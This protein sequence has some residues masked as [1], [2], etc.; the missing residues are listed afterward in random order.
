MPGVAEYGIFVLSSPAISVAMSVYNCE[1]Y[2]VLAIDSILQ[3]S[4]TDFE[5]LIL[6]DGSTD[7]SRAIIDHYAALDSRIRPIHRENKG[8][9]I[10][11][12]QLV[13]EAKAPLIARMDGDDI[14]RPERFA[15]QM[16]FLAANPDYGVLGT[17]TADIDEKGDPFIVSGAD[18]PTTYE[19]FLSAIPVRSALCHPSIIMRRDLVLAAGGYHAAFKHCEDYDLWLRLAHMTKICSLPERLIKYRHSDGQVSNKHIVA[20]QYGT[21]VSRLAYHARAAGRDDPTEHLAELPPLESLDALFN[22]PGAAREARA[23]LVAGLLYSPVAMTSDGFGLLLDHV[24]DGGSKKGLWRTVIR[25]LVR[26]GEPRRAWMLL[27]T[28][29]TN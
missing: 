1:A 20:Q 12:N 16:E 21:V 24:R 5:F 7:G 10:S 17:W 9:I 25:L 6:N 22:M 15:K 14:A 26:M 23:M 3:Q 2:L 4:F 28:L 29:L 13:T 11:L 8:L 27:N 19:G 18:H